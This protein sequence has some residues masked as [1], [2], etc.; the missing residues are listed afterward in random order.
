MRGVGEDLPLACV[1]L[2]RISFSGCRAALAW[3]RRNGEADGA[4]AKAKA[5]S[6][7]LTVL[8]Q[9]ALS[10]GAASLPRASLVVRSNMTS[11]PRS[12]RTDVDQFSWRHREDFLRQRRCDLECDCF[13]P[14]SERPRCRCS[15]Q[16]LRTTS[17]TRHPCQKT[18]ELMRGSQPGLLIWGRRYRAIYE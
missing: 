6:S 2:E 12:P 15:T 16:P 18:G 1:G 11:L 9:H 5:A 17:A 13:S 7:G 14:G 10:V 3:H 4:D 8:K